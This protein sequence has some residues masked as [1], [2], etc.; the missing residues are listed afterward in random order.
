M[1]CDIRH[2]LFL[3]SI[4]GA[5]NIPCLSHTLAS[6]KKSHSAAAFSPHSL[7]THSRPSRNTAVPRQDSHCLA[8]PLQTGTRSLH[9]IAL[10]TLEV[11]RT[12][13]TPALHSIRSLNS[14]LGEVF[15]TGYSMCLPRVG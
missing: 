6:F 12:R 14:A 13:V 10:L 1:S 2:L 8:P 7:F 15:L 9:H 5:L 3:L 4:L 11:G